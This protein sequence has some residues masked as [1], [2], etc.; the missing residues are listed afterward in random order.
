MGIAPVAIKVPKGTGA[1]SYST[2]RTP[3]VRC[4]ALLDTNWAHDLRGSCDASEKCALHDSGKGAKD[5]LVAKMKLVYADPPGS[6]PNLAATGADL[7]IWCWLA[8][9]AHVPSLLALPVR[10][11]GASAKW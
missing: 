5:G 6:P 7:F 11:G 3:V 10:R 1:T 2:A 4:Q 8:T 9:F